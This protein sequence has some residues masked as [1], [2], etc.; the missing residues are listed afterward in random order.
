MNAPI[1]GFAEAAAA[2]GFDWLTE[3]YNTAGALTEVDPASDADEE[4]PGGFSSVYLTMPTM[5]GLNR[6]LA[7]WRR[8]TRGGAAENT[9]ERRWWNLFGYLADVRVWSE[10]DRVDPSLALY[11]ADILSRDPNA[12]V[13]IELDLWFFEMQEKRQTAL[14]G[15]EFL[16]ELEGARILDQEII[17]EIRFHGV[18]VSL[19]ASNARRLVEHLGPLAT[20]SMVMTIRPQ[21]LS[22]FEPPAESEMIPVVRTVP[23]APDE[24]PPLAVLLDGY[25]VQSHQLLRNRLDIEE[26]DVAGADAPLHMRFHG[27]AMAS[28][29]IHGDLASGEEPLGRVLKVVPILAAAQDA[30]VES[31]PTDKL[32][33]AM[34]YRAVEAMAGAE[35]SAPDAVLFNHSVC[36]VAAPFV[37]RPTPWAKLLDFLSHKHRILFVVSAGNIHTPFVVPGYADVAAFRAADPTERGLAILRAVE[38]AKGTR[39]ILSPAE[40]VNALTI[41]ALHADGAPDCPV[42]HVDPFGFAAA[43]LCS[44]VGFGVNRAIK[45]DLAMDGGRQVAQ[46]VPH[47]AGFAVKGWE[48]VHLGQQ[49]AAPDLY[50]ATTTFVRRST[51]TSNAAALATRAG[52][53]IAEALQELVTASG[54]QWTQLRTRAV[55]VKA[56]L[57]HGCR[58][59][60][61]GGLLEGAYPPPGTRKWRKRREAITRFL[62]YGRPAVIG[63][64]GG[65]AS[66][67]TL[68]ADDVI[69]PGGLHEYRIP[70]PSALLGSRELRRITLTLAWSTPIHPAT[71]AYRGVALDIVDVEGKRD[72]WTAVKSLPQPHADDGRR[73]TV[74]HV[75]LEGTKKIKSITPSG[76]FVGVQARELHPSFK[77]STIPYALAVTIEV[78]QTVRADIYTDVQSRARTRT[79]LRERV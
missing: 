28:L 59:G 20:A 2:N 6:L 27:T 3:D 65:D 66:R 62:G 41:G 44:G 63:V 75:V 34:I 52:I 17:S 48:I 30:Q 71:T 45:P 68:L 21:S 67:I 15:L 55:M 50:G 46:S 14:T 26:V 11:V 64:I 77:A 12:L 32:P 54:D 13:R 22:Q 25:P 70:V 78:A 49:A 72:F 35:G 38:S 53:L 42:N 47:A 79:R 40:A 74:I 69:S 4:L 29:I 33:L 36:D 9:M 37:R 58:W 16:L 56:L 51:G 5:A 43:N 76:L 73:G 57:V 23:W 8:Y 10:R 18:L 39:G 24:R 31:T 1:Q 19:P 61:V 7:F 60:A